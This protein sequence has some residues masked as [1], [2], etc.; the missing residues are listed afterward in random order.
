MKSIVSQRFVECLEELYSS[1]RVS[2][3]RQMA[4]HLDFKPQNLSEI[5]KGRRDAPIELIRKAIEE[6]LLSPVYLFSGAGP[7]FTKTKSGQAF[8]VL[9]IVTDR[10]GKE[11]IVHVPAQAQAGY[12]SG[13]RDASFIEEMP[14]YSLPDMRY[15]SG[16][17]R[18]F[19]V[20]G[21]SMEPGI[22]A[23][24]RL[25]CR[26]LE[27]EYWASGLRDRHV[28][29][30]VTST[31]VVVKRISNEL[32][33]AR[34]I[35][36]VSDNDFFAPYYMSVEDIKEIWMVE[37]VIR[38]FDHYP[39]KASSISEQAAS[40]D[41]PAPIGKSSASTDIGSSSMSSDFDVSDFADLLAD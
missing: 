27:P 3:F 16:S 11:Q 31:D 23:Y 24:D 35:L 8:D 18:S 36:A 37:S 28:Y 4:L 22:R 7:K 39:H 12:V 15:R 1:R 26:Y 38:N 5:R 41:D 30:V 2:S 6:Y 17:Y 14:T 19:D 40:I 29:V 25:I 13:Y 20:T 10:S 33:T 9:T 21:S 32:K 34:R